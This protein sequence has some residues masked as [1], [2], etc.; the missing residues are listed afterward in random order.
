[1]SHEPQ[2]VALRRLTG[3]GVVLAAGV[4]ATAALCWAIWG[5]D[6]LTPHPVAR[7]PEAPRLQEH[8]SRNLAGYRTATREADAYGWNDADH[9]SAHIPVRRAMDIMAK[10]AAR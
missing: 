3:I 9:R 1:M 5:G 4:V 10:E 6:S 8:P 2:A 7:L